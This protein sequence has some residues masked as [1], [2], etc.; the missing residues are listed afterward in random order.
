M[1]NKIQ[2]VTQSE[3]LCFTDAHECTQFIR[4][5]LF[6]Y[7]DSLLTL[8]QQVS[9]T[10]VQ[11]IFEFITEVMKMCLTWIEVFPKYYQA[12]KASMAHPNLYLVDRDCAISQCGLEIFTML[13]MC[14]GLHERVNKCIKQFKYP[15]NYQSETFS[16]PQKQS[17]I[18]FL[19]STI[20]MFGD[21]KG[22]QILLDFI[23]VRPKEQ[24]FTCPIP[25]T[26]Y[27]IATTSRVAEI[28]MKEALLTQMS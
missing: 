24:G 1:L 20:N 13:H 16:D 11:K 12:Y 3:F 2:H 22:Y 28:G 14:F 25:L 26:G 10:D 18:A 4:G 19:I 7:F 23:K 15:T 8:Q 17:N 27:A 21:L 5:E 6:I 9:A